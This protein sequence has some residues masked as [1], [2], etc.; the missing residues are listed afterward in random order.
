MLIVPIPK[1]D[2]AFL[3]MYSAAHGTSAEAFL[4]GQV[5]NL[6][7]HLQAP[8]QPEIA[9]ASGIVDPAIDADATHRAYLE[10]KH[11]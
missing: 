7:K 9:L 2:L 11:E 6:R 1:E 5:Q 10:K 4:A 8:L 3:E